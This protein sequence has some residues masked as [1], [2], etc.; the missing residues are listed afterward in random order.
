MKVLFDTNIVLDIIA[1]RESFFQQSYQIFLGV[2]DGHFEGII[3]A[4]SITDVYYIARKNLKDAALTLSLIMKILESLTLVDTTVQDIRQ[5]AASTIA[6]FEDAVVAF[7]AQREGA[8]FIITRN[9]KDFTDFPVPALT[10]EEF[11]KK[12]EEEK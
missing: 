2:V 7:T 11:L 10:P 4:S 12:R 6:D 5:A 3:G 1:Q 8:D 9:A